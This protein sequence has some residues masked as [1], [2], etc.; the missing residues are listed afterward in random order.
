MPV[1]RL[2]ARHRLGDLYADYLSDEEGRIGLRLV[3]ADL[4]DAIVT[5]RPDLPPPGANPVVRRIDPLVHVHA[6]GWPLPVGFAAGRTLRHA[7][8]TMGL[9][10]HGQRVED[11]GGTIVTELRHPCGLVAEH[12]LRREPGRPWLRITTTVRNHGTAPLRLELVTGAVLS[13]VTPFAADDAPGRLRLHRFRSTWSGEGRHDEVLL[14]DLHLE[15]AWGA[16]SIQCERFGQVG[17]MPVRGFVPWV[18]IED[19]GAGVVWA[20]QPDAPASWQCDALRREDAVSISAGPADH[21]LGHWWRDLAPGESY[22]APGVSAACVR[23]DVDAACDALVAAIDAEVAPP[24]A[25]AGLP[26]AFNEWCSSWGVPAHAAVTA[27]AEALRGSGI[28]YL[29][30]DAGWFL[31]DQGAWHNAQGDW[32]PSPR[33]FPDGIAATAAA[34]RA[35]GFIPGLWFEWEVAGRNA[36]LWDRHDWLLC[37]HGVPITVGDRRFLD[38]R[39]P[40]VRDHLRTRMAGLLRDGGFGYLKM[41]YNETAGIGP[42]GRHGPGAELED[43]TLAAQDFVR[44]LRRDLPGLV[45]ECCASGGHRLEPSWLR[46]VSQASFSDVH[47]GRSIPIVA[48]NLHRL[49]PARQ[50]QIWAVLQPGDSDQRMVWS[51]C[52]GFLGRLCVSGTVTPANRPRIDAA[53]AFAAAIAPVMADGRSRRH[54]DAHRGSWSHPAGWQAVVRHG[55]AGCLV[56]VHAYAGAPERLD[57]PLPADSLAVAAAFPGGGATIQGDRLVVDLPGNGDRAG[58]WLLTG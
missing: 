4:V 16:H 40:A 44:G 21:E 1:P 13:D 20:L 31:P 25:E 32:R 54:G 46:L 52:A 8:L 43:A 17:S 33:L 18:G 3:P 53:V 45:I 37:R 42:D 29:T 35:A 14:E 9:R 36:S 49:I 50:N 55:P 51:L 6:A 38:L 39:R 10:L 26:C 58:A 23:G 56:V 57:I 27:V 7:D 34:I 2:H 24:A 12:R 28:R 22:A 19:R 47:E 5:P 30:I 48:A 15:R 11:D 41:D